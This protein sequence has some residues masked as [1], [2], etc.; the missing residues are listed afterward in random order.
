[1][2]GILK[3][4]YLAIGLALMVAFLSAVTVASA[5]LHTTNGVLHGLHNEIFGRDE[6]PVGSTNASGSNA[7]AT[8]EVRH[9]YDDGNFHVQCSDAGYEGASCVGTWGT[10]RCQKRYVGG[11]EGVLT[12]HWV[13]LGPSCPGQIHA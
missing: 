10:R 2:V 11:A 13:R 4:R 8:A 9:Y 12:R 7:W 6:Y 5:Y 3:D 1:M